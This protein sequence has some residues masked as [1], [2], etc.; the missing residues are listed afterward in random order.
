MSNAEEFGAWLE[1]VRGDTAVIV[2]EHRPVPLWQHMMVGQ[3]LFDLF[4]EET[5]A[6]RGTPAAAPELSVNP[7]LLHA[8]RGAEGRGAWDSHWSGDGRGRS[9]GRPER[10]G[11]RPRCDEWGRTGPSR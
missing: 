3:S 7:D 2:S 6:R 9:R 8:I 11:E 4:V 1:E 10:K 5:V